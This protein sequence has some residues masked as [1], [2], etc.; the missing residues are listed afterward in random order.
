MDTQRSK[1]LI[2][3]F[4]KQP[5]KYS[6]FYQSIVEAIELL[7][8]LKV[9]VNDKVEDKGATNMITRNL[10]KIDQELDKLDGAT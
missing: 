6:G 4:N 1:K 10:D 8:V 3:F 5:A 7:A 9:A 2:K